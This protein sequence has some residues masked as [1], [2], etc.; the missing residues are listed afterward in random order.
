MTPTEL[1]EITPIQR[2]NFWLAVV[3]GAGAIMGTAF[4]AMETV[5]AGLAYKLTGS[6]FCVGLIAT[7]FGIGWLWPSLI[8]GSLIEHR[9]RKMPVYIV[10][11]VGRSCTLAAMG[12]TVL[13]WRGDDWTLYWILIALVG[14]FASF[15]GICVVPF[16]DIL[17]KAVPAERIHMCI[18]YRRFFGGILGASSG[19]AA[20]YIL[21][22][23][24]G[25]E[26][27]AQYA[28]LI[29]TGF[30]INAI[31][32]LSY[33]M[34]QEPIEPVDTQRVPFRRFLRRGPQILKADRDYRN[35]YL[36]KWAWAIGAMPQAILVPYAVDMFMA[37]EERTGTWTTVLMITGGV[38]GY[39]WGRVSQRFGARAVLRLSATAA[40]LTVGMALLIE[41]ARFSDPLYA[42]IEAHYW[43]PMFFMFACGAFAK[44]GTELGGTVYM[45]S[46]SP[47]KR[48]PTYWGFMSALSVPLLAMPAIAGL[49]VDTVSYRAT[50][51]IAGVMAIAAIAIPSRLRHRAGDFPKLP[52]DEE[53]Q[54]IAQM[55]TD[56]D[57]IG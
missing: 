43:A 18:G 16:M 9:E 13:L 29:F 7:V 15:G 44:Q 35:Y 51:V 49:L 5:M 45:L 24:A 31:A 37:P 21:S 17:G 32:Y 10:T 54:Q 30:V 42:A 34:V 26:Y 23:R 40:L 47:P 46:L 20:M 50:F 19:I 1:T 11:A 39:L 56:E 38:A 48:R 55:E 28:T 52:F 2:R 4:F 53:D 14:L 6:T 25:I 57:E 22:G 27:P 36:Y 3:N 33:T 8:V 41:V 12:A